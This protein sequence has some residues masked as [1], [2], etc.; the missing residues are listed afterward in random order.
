LPGKFIGRAAGD[1]LRQ[2]L[3]GIVRPSQRFQFAGKKPA[4][5]ALEGRARPQADGAG[6]VAGGVAVSAAEG[7]ELAPPEERLAVQLLGRERLFP[8]ADQVERRGL[9]VGRDQ[10]PD[11]VGVRADPRAADLRRLVSS[12]I[13]SP[14]AASST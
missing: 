8:F 4:G 9:V 12:S 13:F 6:Q 2:F 11:G 7:F 1:Q 5:L 14:R 3:T 10:F